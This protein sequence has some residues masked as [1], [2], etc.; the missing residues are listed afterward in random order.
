MDDLILIRG[1][2]AERADDD[3]RARAAAWEALEARFDPVPTTSVANPTRSRRRAVVAV[4]GAGAI[5]AIA[6]GLLALSTGPTAEPAAAEVLRQT[7]AVAAAGD[8]APEALP[9]PG[10]FLYMKA[11]TVELRGWALATAVGASAACSSRPARST[12]SCRWTANRG[13]L[14]KRPAA[15]AKPRARPDS[16]RTPNRVAGN[17]RAR[18][19]R[20]RST[21]A[22]RTPPTAPI[23]HVLEASRGSIDIEIPKPEGRGLGP[24]FGFPDT[25]GL[26]TEPEA[27]RLSIQDHP[28][29]GTG[30]RPGG[31]PLD[32]PLS[33]EET[34][35]GLWGILEQPVV[36]PKLRAAVFNALAEL[37]DIELDRDAT[38]LAGRP[39]YAI[40]FFDRETGMRVEYIFDPET[41][42]IL[43]E[44]TVLTDP[45]LSSANEGLPAGTVI[46]DVAR[47]Q[48][49]VV[50]SAQETPDE[51]QSGEPAATTGPVYR[52]R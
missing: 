6:A 13:C 49:G 43:G 10:Q 45:E 9:G 23:V 46:R 34:M 35:L 19:C 20:I 50:D 21:R 2:R 51:G 25:S 42:E 27:L 3:P 18:P 11:K 30:N 29:P 26:P 48:T 47:L 7:A 16:S 44:R 41:S 28:L 32:T 31:K 36:D 1:F 24:N 52:I 22:A 8:T 17:R 12:R 40:S 14:R 38:D 37:P 5:A 33:T 15:C 4:A 39:G